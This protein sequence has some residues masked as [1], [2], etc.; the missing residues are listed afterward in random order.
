MPL[1]SHEKSK[2][3]KSS[4]SAS[5]RPIFYVQ[6]QR[7]LHIWSC[8]QN[9]WSKLNV[10]FW[11]V[12]FMAWNIDIEVSKSLFCTNSCSAPTPP[13]IICLLA[14]YHSNSIFHKSCKTYHPTNHSTYLLKPTELLI[15]LAYT[16]PSF[17][18]DLGPG[19]YQ[20]IVIL[21]RQGHTIASL[22]TSMSMAWKQLW[23]L[24]PPWDW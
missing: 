17:Q 16:W 7:I 22:E 9:A 19:L 1:L 8:L 15:Q 13:S 11:L 5:L 6:N 3:L 12:N 21:N 24:S 14:A 10:A 2:N 20:R 18:P 23:Q 4:I